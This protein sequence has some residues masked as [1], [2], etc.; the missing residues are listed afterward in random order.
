MG[1]EFDELDFLFNEIDRLDNETNECFDYYRR[2]VTES[3]RVQEIAENFR[4]YIDEIDE[5]F[6]KKTKLTKVDIAFLALATGLQ[7]L[8]Q[9]AL[10]PKERTNDKEAAEKA[11]KKNQK[12]N[13]K[14]FDKEDA[15]NSKKYYYASMGDILDVSRYVPYDI[16]NGSK[17]YGLGGLNKGL[18][19]D[20]R[21]KVPGH[22]PI[23][24]LFYGTAN[25][26]TNTITSYTQQSCH[27]KKI[28][29]NKGYEVPQ[30][31]AKASTKE[32]FTK[33]KDRFDTDKPAV[34]AALIKQIYHIKSDE[35]SKEG[36]PIPFVGK[37]SPELAKTLAN[38]GVDWANSKQVAKQAT[39]AVLIDCIIAMIHR[40]Y[41]DGT[42]DMD[43]KLYKVR[44]KKILDYS[45]VI[46]STSNI[47]YVGVSAAM[48]DTSATDKLDICGIAYTVWKLI[49][50][51]KYM[52]D[53]KKEFMDK[54]IDELIE[55]DY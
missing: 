39:V 22:D 30:I 23:L 42:T 17:K 3:E 6:A 50:D 27:V 47:I 52:A 11:H 31:Y 1:N 43:L 49:K 10:A 45:G 24:G 40:L 38:Y 7:V 26:L 9:Y 18:G 20:H 44:T 46:A 36:I 37:L 34:A 16:T 21:F 28:A 13:E 5:N 32:V 25:I 54:N 55:G 48:G 19:S 53:V 2:I 33:V 12:Q 41:Y 51:K 14:F 8:R 15:T 29:N 35:L 4:E